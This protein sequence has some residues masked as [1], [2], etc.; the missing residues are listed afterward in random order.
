[1]KQKKLSERHEREY[2]ELL[3]GGYTTRASGSKEEKNDV[4]S[5][6]DGQYF[7]FSVELK[8]TQAKSFSVTKELWDL[9]RQRTFEKSDE[10]RPA[11]GV[12]LYGPDGSFPGRPTSENDT[13]VLV[14]LTVIDTNDFVE[15]LEK[16]RSLGE[17]TGS[18]GE[19]S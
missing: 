16:I 10:C 8:C 7:S 15:M 4:H 12:R 3:P 17:G 6:R 18:T 5:E 19:E 11:L 9:T 1:M 13:P 14:D 2:A